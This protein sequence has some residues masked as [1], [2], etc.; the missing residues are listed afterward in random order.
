[1]KIRFVYTALQVRNLSKSIRFYTQVLGMKQLVRKYVKETDGEM[2]VLKSG[3]TTL[4]L[5]HYDNQ[6]CKR[7]NNLDHLAFE[8][9]DFGEF[10]SMLRRRRIRIHEYLET[11]RWK[12]FF[13]SD[14]DGNWLEIFYRK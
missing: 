6:P 14:P 9:D 12:R 1:M 11:E 13:I 8:V 4:E 7:G 5:N 10:Q 3:K 2:C